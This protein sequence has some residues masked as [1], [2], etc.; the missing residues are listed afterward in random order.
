MYNFGIF[1]P[2][3]W[4][5]S[6]KV[7]ILTYHRFSNEKNP[8]KTSAEEFEAHL[9]YLSKNNHVLPLSKI[10]DFLKEG[11]TLP[12]NSTAITIDDGYRDAF[13]IAFPLLK[14]FGLPAT[15][16]AITDFLD[17]KIWVWTDLMRYILLNTKNEQIA[18]EFDEKD[19]V[20]T[21]LTDEA[22]K[23]EMAMHINSRLKKLPNDQRDRKI[24]DIAKALNVE[25]PVVPSAEFAA[26]NWSEACEMDAEEIKIESHTVTHP[27]LPN[28]SAEQINIEMRNSK[29]R[30]EK[31]LGRRVEHFC[32][33]NGSLNEK[34]R[35]SAENA[36]YKS[37]VTTIYGFN[38]LRTDLHLLHRID[39]QSAI[40]NFAQS[41]SGF[42]ALRN[43]F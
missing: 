32:Y 10:I 16:Y 14:K 38:D 17:E 8:S 19:K 23:V 6:G 15:V 21:V 41:V 20:E 31:M 28:V 1:A 5:N 37:A 33:P 22:R 40:E 7:L 27:I 2:F 34:V 30:L 43:R 29:A 3:R 36:G 18:I 4:A 39:A 35:C 26:M 9:D 12:P 11:K 24:N 13:D 25:I 42:E